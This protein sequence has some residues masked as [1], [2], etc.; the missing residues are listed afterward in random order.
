MGVAATL[1][2]ASAAAEPTSIA[3]LVEL[4]DLSNVSVSPDGRYVLFRTE[5]A[6][7]ERNSY[8]L[9]WHSYDTRTGEVR[10]I[11]SAGN[12]IYADPGV[13]EE[14]GPIWLRDG[15]SFVYR[16][17]VDGAIGVWRSRAD[18][19]GA[20]PLIVRDADVE[21][22]ESS[23]HGSA[24]TYALGPSRAEIAR[25][26]A[27]E[28]ESGIRIDG[29]V[30]LA[31]NL[32]RGGSIDG[33][34]ASQRFVGYWFV[35]GGLLWRSPR[36]AYRF[37]IATRQELPVGGPRVPE[38]FHPPDSGSATR[39]DGSEAQ[40]HWDGSNG[41]VGARIGGG[42]PI[43]CSDA[44]CRTRH[45]SWLAWRPGTDQLLLAF[46][47]GNR[48]QS[49]ALWDVRRQRLRLVAAADGLLSGNRWSYVPCALSHDSAFC[50]SAS[51]GSPPRLERVDLES[52]R[53]ETI[54]DPNAGLRAT[55]RPEVEQLAWSGSRGQTFRGTLLTSPGAE[56]LQAPLFVNYYKC[57][58][59]L[60]G[61]EGDAWPIP[62]LLDAG[63]A[64]ACVNAAPFSGPQ[65]AVETYR[66]GL[67]GVRALVSRLGRRGMIDRRKVAMGGFSFGSEVATWVAMHSDLLAALSIESAQYEQGAYWI[68]TLGAPDRAKMIRD[69]W[70]LGAP[71]ETPARWRTVSPALNAS[72]IHAA[73]I[74]QLPE[75][76]ARRIP[77]LAARLMASRTPAELFAFPDEDHVALQP[78]HRAAIYQRNLDWFRYWL[79]GYVD[80]DRAKADQYRRWALLKARRDGSLA[81]GSH[82]QLK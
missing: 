72:S 37:D 40:A 71:G 62:A 76:E 16:A 56:P 36:Q 69:S 82:P 23:D 32:F 49:L 74:M 4:T 64:V 66:T 55:Y 27:A 51:A 59:F 31:Q 79:Q 15:R 54:F 60:R 14:N 17:L 73:T 6:E 2:G 42:A 61:G 28:Y 11:A 38:G 1:S 47:D 7:L 63:F 57:D 26:E 70:H 22:L 43:L 68:D 46:I 67:D 65:D 77:E 81:P 41:K 50:V 20:Q 13:I 18:V 3:N 19:S 58:G 9:E 44:Q 33:R 29:S 5:H 34:M 52:G 53:R 75:Q 35:R 48:R 8:A 12:P 39:D 25:A 80:R 78:R 30:D 24:L 10:D 45:V 21:Q